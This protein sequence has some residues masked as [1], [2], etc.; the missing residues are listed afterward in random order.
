MWSLS[1]RLLI[2][3]NNDTCINLQ[4]SINFKSDLIVL[5][6]YSF[7]IFFYYFLFLCNTTE[8][9]VYLPVFSPK[10]LNPQFLNSSAERFITEWKSWFDP[11][12]IITGFFVDIE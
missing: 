8:K 5:I 3:V 1:E 10:H 7:S 6:V 4:L 2:R 11:F 12:H 9:L